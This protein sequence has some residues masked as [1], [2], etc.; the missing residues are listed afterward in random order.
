M[1]LKQKTIRQVQNEAWDQVISLQDQMHPN[2]RTEKPRTLFTTGLASEVGGVCDQV[3]HLDGGGSQLLDPNKWNEG[4]VLHDLVDGWVMTVLVAERSGFDEADFW[5]EW[6]NV[7]K[8]Q[9]IERANARNGA[10]ISKE[11]RI[12]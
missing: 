12:V 9:L 5:V 3:T 7:V 10:I 1:S 11:L 6:E 4:K 8:P 2:W